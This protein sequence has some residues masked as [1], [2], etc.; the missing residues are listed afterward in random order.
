M[1]RF[2]KSALVASAV[3][4]APLSAF[5]DDAATVDYAA[6]VAE[7]GGDAAAG[8]RVYNQCKACHVVNA[9]QN[10]VGPHQV[11]VIG[12]PAGVVDG[13]R[14]SPAMAN[15]GLVWD[16][17]TLTEYLKDPRGYLPGTKMAFRGLR[18]DQQIADVITYIFEEGGVYEAP[19]Q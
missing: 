18:N 2:L 10:R 4:L 3:A 13:Y 6:Q 5:A 14:Y 19:T 9:E 11:G 7:L 8:A 17:P 16:V 15:S 1:N 12:R